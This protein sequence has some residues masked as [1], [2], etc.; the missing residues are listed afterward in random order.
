MV[1]N[2][3][4]KFN[5]NEFA[6]DYNNP[7]YKLGFNYS[8]SKVN[9]DVN[10]KFQKSMGINLSSNIYKDL[11]LTLAANKNLQSKGFIDHLIGIDYD[12]DC[13]YTKLYVQRDFTRDRDKKPDS[14]I[15][16]K[17]ELKTLTD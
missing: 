5:R 10:S 17:L 7:V 9:A 13:I 12:A 16:F 8:E 3:S 2:N 11:S 6:L 15:I 4:L 1:D 14:K